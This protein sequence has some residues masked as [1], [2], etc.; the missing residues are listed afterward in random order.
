MPFGQTIQHR[1]PTLQAG[2]LRH[3]IS[4]VANNPAQDSTGGFDLNTT[5]LYAD[6]WASVEA[7]SGMEQFATE[8]QVSKVTYQIVLRYIKAAPSWKPN[9]NYLTGA[10]VNDA[11]GNLQVAVYGGLSGSAAP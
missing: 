6:V 9:T 1:T 4:I 8:S 11:A 10:L 2:K 3:R 7:L 5:T